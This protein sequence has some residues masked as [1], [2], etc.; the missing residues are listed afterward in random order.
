MLQRRWANSNPES[1]SRP[2][3]VETPRSPPWFPGLNTAVTHASYALLD[4]SYVGLQF[5]SV[6]PEP[7]ELWL[8]HHY[9]GSRL[10]L[11]TRCSMTCCLEGD[12]VQVLL[13]SL[14][15]SG[16]KERSRR[17]QEHGHWGAP[18]EGLYH[19]CAQ[20]DLDGIFPAG[21]KQISCHNI[22]AKLPFMIF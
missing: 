18:C 6:G 9:A 11:R 5:V 16:Q 2:G 8:G 3:A 15:G 20:P 14:P 1:V 13:L 12:P 21:F 4:H 19:P 7:L 17:A 10:D 22:C